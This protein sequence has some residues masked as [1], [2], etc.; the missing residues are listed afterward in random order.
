MICVADA[1]DVW[2]RGQLLD[3]RLRGQAVGMVPRC[4]HKIMVTTIC[5]RVTTVIERLT[6]PASLAS[7]TAALVSVRRF[8]VRWTIAD[9]FG[10]P[11]L[12]RRATVRRRRVVFR[13]PLS[14]WTAIH[15]SDASK[16]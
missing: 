3:K 7:G 4:Y 2:P 14:A 8:P 12:H 11:G 5:S 13:N 6:S 10:V 1:A 9:D 16:C 15:G